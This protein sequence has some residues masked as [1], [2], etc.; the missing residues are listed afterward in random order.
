MRVDTT[1]PVGEAMSAPLVTISRRA[2]LREAAVLM[3]ERD[4]SSLFVPGASA[5]IVTTTDVVTAVAED[6]DLSAVTVGEV[7]TAD[8]ERV[9]TAQELG[10]AAAMMTALGIKHLPV[11]DDDG[12]YVGMLSTTDLASFLG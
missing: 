8:V 6:R 4:I 5:G 7:M 11:V 2:T 12:D 9:T 3:R 10:E 1:T